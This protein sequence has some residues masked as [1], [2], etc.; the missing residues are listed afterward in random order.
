[1]DDGIEGVVANPP[2][3]SPMNQVAGQVAGSGEIFD[4]AC[5]HQQACEKTKLERIME[6][7]AQQGVDLIIEVGLESTAGSKMA[8]AWQ[9]QRTVRRR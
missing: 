1:M 5:W 3:L 8:L 2:S 7:F 9:N 4:T 6:T